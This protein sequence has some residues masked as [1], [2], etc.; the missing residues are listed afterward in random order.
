M[1]AEFSKVEGSKLP[2][3]N[4]ELTTGYE[5]E[6]DANNWRVGL[7]QTFDIN[8]RRAAQTDQAVAVRVAAR[9]SYAAAWQAKATQVL[10]AMVAP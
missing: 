1:N 7:G 2:L 10:R 3:Y 8:R 6:G 5:R 9:Q 4:P